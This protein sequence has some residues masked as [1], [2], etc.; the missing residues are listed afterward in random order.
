MLSV[1]MFQQIEFIMWLFTF[2]LL[3]F[4]FKLLPFTFMYWQVEFMLGL[5]A[6][7][8]SLF[9]FNFVALCSCHLAG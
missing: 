9:E 4:E 1:F 5:F 7:K 3:S 8:L 2:M 6:F